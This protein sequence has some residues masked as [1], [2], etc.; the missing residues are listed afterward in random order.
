MRNVLLMTV[1]LMVV[2]AMAGAQEFV[3]CK[4]YP[5]YDHE[6]VADQPYRVGEA[7][8]SDDF[9]GD[10]SQWVWEGDVEPQITEERMELTTRVG[11]TVWFKEKLE[12]NV[13]IEY[14]RQ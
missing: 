14:R 4:P 11:L 2:T 3:P 13:M 9:S 7:L 12:G 6:T 8:Y 10:L 5:V 1:A